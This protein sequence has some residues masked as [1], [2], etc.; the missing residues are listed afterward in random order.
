[1]R[2]ARR[3]LFFSLPFLRPCK[4]YPRLAIIIIRSSRLVNRCWSNDYNRHSKNATCGGGTKIGKNRPDTPIARIYGFSFLREG[5]PVDWLLGH[6]VRKGEVCLLYEFA[7][8]RFFSFVE[9]SRTRRVRTSR[10]WSP[11]SCRRP[12][13]NVFDSRTLFFALA[14]IML[15]YRRT[16][17][18]IE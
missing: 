12:R 14:I 6:Y 8:A 3:R 4:Q 17:I 1:M 10:I 18:E 9:T 15:F 7:T 2:T 16:E 11:H 13:W 5:A